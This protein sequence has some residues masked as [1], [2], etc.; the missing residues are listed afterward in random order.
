MDF[1]P[2]LIAEIM[3]LALLFVGLFKLDAINKSL[4]SFGEFAKNAAEEIKTLRSKTHDHANDIF[5]LKLK[6]DERDKHEQ[7]RQSKRDR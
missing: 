4:G 6:M 7:S 2:A 3:G 1:S 5:A